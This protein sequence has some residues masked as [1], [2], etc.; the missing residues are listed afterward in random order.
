MT[1][2]II[3]RFWGKVEKTASCWNWLAGKDNDGYGRFGKQRA[4]QV[5]FVLKYRHIPVGK[6]LNHTCQNRACVRWS[7]LEALTH[8][9]HMRKTPGTFGYKWAAATHCIRG[10]LL[11]GENLLPWALKRGKRFCRT[12]RI[13]ANRLWRKANPD[14]MRAAQQNWSL[15][16]R[17]NIR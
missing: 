11:A 15:R 3:D 6:E 1:Q 16:Q 5:A 9:E 2:D 14:K 7:H 13:E 4:H 12:C 8:K 10:H 17:L